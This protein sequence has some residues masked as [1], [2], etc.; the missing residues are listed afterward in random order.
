[1][2]LLRTSVVKFEM[3]KRL[4]HFIYRSCVTALVLGI[5]AVVYDQIG[6]VLAGDHFAL[7]LWGIRLVT[8][9]IFGFIVWRLCVGLRSGYLLF[10]D[11]DD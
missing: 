2:Q 7:I 1:M 3:S 6:P 9:A 4:K 5:V 8:F 11:F 10:D